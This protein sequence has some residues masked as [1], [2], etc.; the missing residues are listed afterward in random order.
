MNLLSIEYRIITFVGLSQK[1]KRRKMCYVSKEQTTMK[2]WYRV[3]QLN[4]HWEE[5]KKPKYYEK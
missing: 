3:G 2:I 1:K 4:R 5:V